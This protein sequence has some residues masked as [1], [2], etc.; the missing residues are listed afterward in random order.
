MLWLGHQVVFSPPPF[1]ALEEFCCKCWFVGETARA[2]LLSWKLY[3]PAPI[4]CYLYFIW[5][6]AGELG[7]D[8]D[9]LSFLQIWVPSSFFF[10]LLSSRH[11][12]VVGWRKWLNC[13]FSVLLSQFLPDS[14][15]HNNL[16]RLAFLSLWG[17]ICVVLGF[18]RQ[19]RRILIFVLFW[20]EMQTVS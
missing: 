7:G 9:F 20:I 8:L 1:S 17:K 4:A 10:F 15:I 16:D 18:L 2:S 3:T 11:L 19:D 13:Q 14:Q 6:T 12:K 5:V